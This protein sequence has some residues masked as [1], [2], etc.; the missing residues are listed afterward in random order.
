MR[1]GV[2]EVRDRRIALGR[3]PRNRV[4]R[5]DRHVGDAEQG[6][7]ARREDLEVATAIRELETDQEAFGATDPVA[8]HR[9]DRFRPTVELVEV[10]QQFIGIGGD[11]HEPLRDFAP[12]DQRAGTPATAV[13]HLLVREH[14]LVDRVPVDDGGL[15]VDQAPLI[16]AGE[17]PLLPAIIIGVAG[18][19]LA[20][21]VIGKAEALQLAAH[22]VDVGAGPARRRHVVL[23]RGVLGRQ[24]ESVPAH[25]LQDILAQH[26][27]VTRDDVADGVI[28]HVPHVQ[29]SARVG[30]HAQ[31]I[32]FFARLVLDSLEGIRGSPLRLDDGFEFNR[33]VAFLHDDQMVCARRMTASGRVRGT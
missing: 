9:L 30:E 2:E 31:A 23:D 10:V 27:L 13:D 1:A 8:L 33:V 20:R 18:R 21:P 17:E 15:A 25:G 7:R 29:A 26:A 4:L 16:E 32:E 14:R 6:V 19:K 12:L 11:A 22:V 5:C 28:A 24:P 3:T